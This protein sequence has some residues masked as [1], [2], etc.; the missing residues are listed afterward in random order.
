MGRSPYLGPHFEFREKTPGNAPYLK[1]I[2]CFNFGA[3]LSH[4]HLSLD[5]PPIS[6]GAERL[7]GG[8]AASFFLQDRV[9]H[10]E[11]YKAYDEPE[12]RHEDFSFLQEI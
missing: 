1:N 11:K 7:A 2:H 5:I 4:A 10:Y 9:K 8:I 3:F 12:F 6:Y